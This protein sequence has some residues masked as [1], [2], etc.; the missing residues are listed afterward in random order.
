MIVLYGCVN[1]FSLKQQQ[2]SLSCKNF[3]LAM[4]HQQTNW[5]Q[6]YFFSL[7]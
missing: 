6:L 3:G 1:F 7:P 4:D 2:Q 5:A